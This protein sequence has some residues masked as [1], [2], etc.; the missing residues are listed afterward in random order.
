MGLVQK[1]LSLDFA[2]FWAG[3][4]AFISIVVSR[5][6]VAS[7][8]DISIY[9]FGHMVHHI[10]Y[11]IAVVIIG[12][13]LMVILG[14]RMHYVG[15]VVLS[16]IFGGGLGWITDEINFIPNWGHTYT[17]ALYNSP[18]NVYAD[19]LLLF[20]LFAGSFMASRFSMAR[21]QKGRSR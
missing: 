1:W 19:L 12:A 7:G 18:V 20:S 10:Y 16:G 13:Y 17:L 15:G 21:T 11:G 5:G 9:A 2:L 4:G 8:G 14:K 6:Y 3:I